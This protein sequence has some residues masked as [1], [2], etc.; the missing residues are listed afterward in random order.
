GTGDGAGAEESSP[1]REALERDALLDDVMLG[2]RLKEGLDLRVVASKY[3]HSAARRVEEGASEGLRLGWVVRDTAARGSHGGDVGAGGEKGGRK[4][5]RVDV[6]DGAV[7]DGARGSSSTL[8]AG[9]A[10][11]A[12]GDDGR[13]ST[14]RGLSDGGSGGRE[15][16]RRAAEVARNSGP[17]GEW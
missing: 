9:S 10:S 13:S 8:G 5:G 12:V 2:F 14:G 17:I 11:G 7:C 6:D 1:S 16:D 15:E 4:A 3:G